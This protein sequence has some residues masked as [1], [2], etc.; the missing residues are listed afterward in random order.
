LALPVTEQLNE[1]SKGLDA[2]APA[3]ILSLLLRSQVKAVNI[4]AH[5]L[6]EIEQAAQL[7]ADTINKGGN[8]I[9]AAAGSSAFMGL[10][11]GLE[12][13]GTF[14]I[15]SSRIKML[16]AGNTGKMSDMTGFTED[17]TLQ[18]GHD[19]KAANI[20]PNDC[21]ICISASGTTPYTLAA[22]QLARDAGAKSIGVANNSDTPILNKAD[23]AILLNTPPEIIPGSTRLGAGTAQK[24]ALNMMST[25][26]GVHLG[27]VHDGYMVNLHVDN[28]KL[29]KRACSIIADVTGC[30][31]ANAKIY[32]DK[33]NGSVK[34]A[35]MLASGLS[36]IGKANE[37][38]E[39]NGYKLRPSLSVL[40]GL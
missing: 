14:G 38:L 5:S 17:D 7:L 1:M 25:L 9:Y 15:S 3:A 22:L 37:I 13:P 28:I 18:A 27:H 26:M 12:L 31:A 39:S 16:I 23:V 6:A 2:L 32:L 33:S 30:S 4:V 24:I 8:I 34:L 29:E 10:A 36:D 21:M 19:V 11:D 40:K 20:S 35:I